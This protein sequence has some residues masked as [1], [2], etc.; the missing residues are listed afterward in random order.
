MILT[1]GAWAANLLTLTPNGLRPSSS[2]PID[3]SAI[4][5]A[6]KAAAANPKNAQ[7]IFNQVAND[8]NNR[9]VPQATPSRLR[10]LP[11][12]SPPFPS[13]DKRLVRHYHFRWRRPVRR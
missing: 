5:D 9:L 3:P 12:L 6:M 4:A 11:T 1:T 13:K 8:P 2:A 7:A 10:I